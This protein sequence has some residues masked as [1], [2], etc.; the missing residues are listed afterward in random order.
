MYCMQLFPV[1][2]FEIHHVLSSVEHGEAGV[3]M[4]AHFEHSMAPVPVQSAVGAAVGAAVQSV[5]ADRYFVV[6]PGMVRRQLNFFARLQGGHDPDDA[7]LRGDDA[8]LRV[9]RPNACFFASGAFGI[10][11]GLASG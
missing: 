1:A 8:I 2:R 4:Q 5:L 10:A 11:S 7:I 3:C 6:V 9:A